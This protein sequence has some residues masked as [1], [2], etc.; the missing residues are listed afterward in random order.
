[1]SKSLELSREV[2]PKESTSFPWITLTLIFLAMLPVTMIVPVYKEIVK[3][4][5]GGSGYGVAW[6]QSSA[7]LGSFL[8]SPLAGWISDRLGVRRTL[9]AAFSLVDA[10]LLVLLP[11]MPDQASLF[12]LRFLEGG[13]HIFVIGLLLASISDREKD[14]ENRFY[15]KGILFGLAGT[16]LTLGGGIGQSLGFLGNSNPLLPFFAGGGILVLLGL[17]SFLFLRDSRIYKSEKIYAEN[18]K[19]L[20]K[21]S[22]LL[23][24]PILFH[25][26]DRFTVGYFLS[27]LNLHLRE[28]LGF[29]PGKVGSLFGTMFLLMSLLS[30]PAA[31]LSKRWNSIGLVWIGSFIYGIAQASTGF[32]E[33]T[34]ALTLSMVACGIGAGIMYVPAMRLASSLSPPGMNATTMT[35]FTGLGSFGFLLGPILSISLE[36]ALAENIGKPYS[37]AWTGIVFGGLEILLVLLTLPLFRKIRSA[38]NS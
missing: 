4:R 16:L 18:A 17:V 28:D 10:I 32:L 26:V 35:V 14:P 19:A 2:G 13:A 1:M 8:F 36:N 30:L 5:F 24:V 25:F 3:D 38:E 34:S 20:L 12:F 9:I 22:P 23:L 6:F 27:S 7:M 29:T 11:F 21:F 15:N 33:S 37:I 31:V